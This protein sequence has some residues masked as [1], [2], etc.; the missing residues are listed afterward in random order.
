MPSKNISIKKE[1][2]HKLELFK[3]ENESFSGVIDR[4]ICKSLEDRDINKCFGL[5]K[6]LTN[7]EIIEIKSHNQNMRKKFAERFS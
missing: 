4:L 7:N 2:Y 1:I 3:K 5:W 6:D